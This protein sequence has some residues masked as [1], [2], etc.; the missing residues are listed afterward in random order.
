MLKLLDA[1]SLD[2]REVKRIRE[3]LDRAAGEENV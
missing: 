2:E 1:D 3:L